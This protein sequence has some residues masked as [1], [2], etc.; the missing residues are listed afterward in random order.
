[1]EIYGYK[2]IKTKKLY[3]VKNI[4]NL[5]QMPENSMAFFKFNESFIKHC[6]KLE[7]E[8]CIEANSLKEVI[9][10]NSF[11]SKL[12]IVPKFLLKTA[13]KTAEHYLFDSKIAYIILN[14]DEIESL[15]KLQID[16][17]VLKKGITNGSI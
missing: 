4:E 2:A 6:K 1:M 16:A 5:K 8:F 17:V 15:A 12:I 9:L 7:I 14:I 10:A 13:Q 11:G 3:R